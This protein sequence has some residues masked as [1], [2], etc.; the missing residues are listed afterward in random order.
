MEINPNF[1]V[2]IDTLIITPTQTILLEIKNYANIVLFDERSGKTTKISPGGQIE[3]W[4]AESYIHLPVEPILVMANQ[5]NEIYTAFKQ[6]NQEWRCQ[7]DMVTAFVMEK[8]SNYGEPAVDQ[9]GLWKKVIGELFEDFLLFFAPELY[10]HVDFTKEPDFLQQ[11]LF[12]EVV[13]KKKG[14][15]MADQLVKVH[16]KDGKEKWILIHVEV[17]SENEVDFS[18]RMF[19][20][21]YRIYDRYD[22]KI[23][24]LAIMTSPHQ[25]TASQDFHY[26]YFGTTLHYAYTNCKIVDYDYK[27]LRK[28]E[29]LFSKIVLAAK[30]VH[31]TKDEDRKR[32][33]FKRKLMREIVRNQ[34]YSRTAVQ[35]VLHFVDY[36]L[37]LPEELSWQLSEKI[38][39]ILGKEQKLM[40]LYNEENASPTITNIFERKRQEGVL[41]GEIKGKMEGKIE[42]RH[43]IAR[44]LLKQ[45][46]PLETIASATKLT[47]E[48]LGMLKNTFNKQ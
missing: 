29:K 41:E 12:Q 2:Q 16:F 45:N 24:A 27:A 30:Y 19:Q 22:R 37:R 21:F 36:L 8:S 4:L 18:E 7:I 44:N 43:D 17:Q 47:L 42:E 38:R 48:E 23:V 31:E 34:Q 14:R 26:N 46:V 40:E 28:S 5:K 10:E 20:Y 15:R 11:E 33:L 35:A 13:D 25:S 9:D 3:K 6:M 39:P 1:R 32:Y